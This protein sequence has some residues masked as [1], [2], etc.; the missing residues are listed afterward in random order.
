MQKARPRKPSTSVVTPSTVEK[1]FDGAPSNLTQMVNDNTVEETGDSPAPKSCCGGL[2]PSSNGS[3][4]GSATPSARQNSHG[5]TTPAS[6]PTAPEFKPPLPLGMFGIGGY[7]A[8]DTIG[9]NHAYPDVTNLPFEVNGVARH[10]SSPDNHTATMVPHSQDRVSATPGPSHS[11]T[12]GSTER[13]HAPIANGAQANGVHHSYNLP[14]HNLYAYQPVISQHVSPTT[15][16]AQPTQSFVGLNMEPTF[17]FVQQGHQ[18]YTAAS[19]AASFVG[20]TA[21]PEHE[22]NCGPGCRCFACPVHPQNSS[23]TDFVKFHHDL[24][25]FEEPAGLS[26][27]NQNASWNFEDPM[28]STSGMRNTRLFN[29]IPPQGTPTQEL[30]NF[31]LRQGDIPNGGNV[32]VT[33]GRSDSSTASPQVNHTTPRATPVSTFNVHTG[34]LAAQYDHDS[35]QSSEETPTLSPS[36]FFMQSYTLPGCDDNTG[37]CHC[38]EGCQCVGCLTH[39]G[40]QETTPVTNSYCNFNIAAMRSEHGA[41]CACPPNI[42]MHT[43]S[44]VQSPTP[45]SFQG[46]PA[47]GAMTPATSSASS[48]TSHHGPIYSGIHGPTCNCPGGS[49]VEARAHVQ[50]HA[51]LHGQNCCC[52]DGQ[53]YAHAQAVAE[54]RIHEQLHGAGCACPGVGSSR[55]TGW[56]GNGMNGIG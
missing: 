13:H 1:A 36:S 52:P 33:H 43:Q 24:M 49:V 10:L 2:A 8:E 23:T 44:I 27:M 40:H 26:Q 50:A 12:N 7:R 15:T 47:S 37:T 5:P 9:W 46:T 51:Q 48:P 17:P 41:D 28:Y 45:S 42:P 29:S 16:R 4:E 53:M 31:H 30:E 35:P 20:M 55:P 3:R 11:Y 54:A 56:M 18:S 34:I 19:D 22:C 14:Q 25:A 21:I 32:T 38:G 6:Q 39:S